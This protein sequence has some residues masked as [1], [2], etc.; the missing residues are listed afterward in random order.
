MDKR[1][2]IWAFG[3]VLYEMLTGKRTFTGQTTTDLVAAVVRAEPEWESLP[4]DTPATL[5]KLLRRC[6]TRERKQ[7]LQAIGDARID[8]EEMLT[9]QVEE[10]TV[11]AAAATYTPR[12]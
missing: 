11:T 6:L 8:I 3:A 7:R 10:T 4:G 9:G 5:G 12:Q 2:D 1:S